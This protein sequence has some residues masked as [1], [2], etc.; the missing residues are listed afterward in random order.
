MDE[1]AQAART[2]FFWWLFWF[3]LI[4]FLLFNLTNQSGRRSENWTV[5]QLYAELEKGTV[6]EII[7]DR[8]TAEVTGRLKKEKEKDSRWFITQVADP[9]KVQE[10]AVA[11]GIPCKVFEAGPSVFWNI[12]VPILPWVLLTWLTLRFLGK[13]LQRSGVASQFTKLKQLDEF[14]IQRKVATR[15][16][17]IAG[18]DESKIE[19]QEVVEALKNPKLF[20]QAGARI[21]RGVLL[22][23]A[24][25]TGKTLLA[26]AI[27]GEAGVPYIGISG[28]DFVE[29]FVGVG[30]GR[31][32]TLFEKARELAPSIIFVD[33]I[34]AVAR[35]RGY[36]TMAHDEREQTLNALL[37][38]M[39]GFSGRD[40][41]IV[42]AATNRPE[43]LDPALVRPGRFDRQVIVP[44][45]D[46][47]GREAILKIHTAKKKLREDVNLETIARMTINFSGADLENLAN[48]AAIFA[49]RR[50]L[51]LT[52][53]LAD[54]FVA[55][56][57]RD[58]LKAFD[59]ITLGPERK[60][61]VMSSEERK[62]T[63]Y[64]EAG[65][66]LVT[67]FSKNADPLGKVTIV[68]HGLAMGVTM[69]LPKEDRRLFHKSYLLDRLVICM[70][71]RA[72]EMLKFDDESS[73][74]SNDFEQASGIAFSMICELGM[75]EK[76][77]KI[78]Y[79]KR[80]DFLKRTE[81]LDCSPETKLLIEG[82]VKK[83]T[84]QAYER[85]MEILT[86]HRDGLEKLAAAL[87]ERETLNADEV[88]E[89]LG[90]S[91]P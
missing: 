84:D 29:M 50:T 86:Q 6:E 88:Y 5:N 80:L 3:F 54:K 48:E 91:K 49:V 20:E 31:V 51:L 47:N 53:P 82:E 13:A 55:I 77:G 59:K 33:E 60:S 62:I 30:A 46:L 74:A 11:K 40:G 27:A 24:P 68:P 41:V 89:L 15:F 7:I 38:E 65:H 17:D 71:G 42:I 67:V 75:N 18:I 83:L 4:S 19:V 1:K 58:F 36:S 45:P 23:G 43:I 81:M 87:L 64:H 22:V 61:L 63:A 9:A 10:L 85:A 79:A 72:A 90:E 16:T 37:R 57:H 66:T 34:D 26:K 76:V 21:P 2:R 70:G 39:D 14:E 56:T 8:K 25:G 69:G 44:L 78:I 12:I 73:G 32:R 52:V 35:A 28:S